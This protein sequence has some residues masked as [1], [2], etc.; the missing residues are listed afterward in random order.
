MVQQHVSH[1]SREY[2]EIPRFA[3]QQLGLKICLVSIL[4]SA[5]NSAGFISRLEHV[6]AC[7]PKSLQKAKQKT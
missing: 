2:V 1:C 4:V 5:E 7:P 3:L 6:L